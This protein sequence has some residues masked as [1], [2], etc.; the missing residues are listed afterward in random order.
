[1]KTY[2]NPKPM[3]TP[4]PDKS[5]TVKIPRPPVKKSPKPTPK[6]MKTYSKD[7]D[8]FA[9]ES[10]VP[11]PK[12]YA[13]PPTRGKT[14]NSPNPKKSQVSDEEIMPK[15]FPKPKGNRRRLLDAT[16]KMNKEAG[17]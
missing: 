5:D 14:Q 16:N 7:L 10:R 13:S 2:R 17:Y 12:G 9:A 6:P 11:K 3:P 4:A 8:P 1:M 15:K